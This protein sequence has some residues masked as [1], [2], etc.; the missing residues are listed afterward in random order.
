M[1]KII[2]TF[3]ISFF[4]FANTL[5]AQE[6]KTTFDEKDTFTY[7][8]LDVLDKEEGDLSLTGNTETQH[9]DS[10]TSLA[11]RS[12]SDSGIG[13]TPGRLSV[14]LTGGANYD[15]PIAVPPGINGIV[16]EVSLSYN[17]QSGNGI[18]GFGWNISGVSTISRIPASKF[19]DN[20]ID[21]VDFDS[22][23]RFALDG[24]RLILKSGTYGGNGAQ[25]DTGSIL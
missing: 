16:P 24:E 20:Q 8:R 9:P 12:S 7:E 11:A 13:E 19:H 10:E 18:A 15:I 21:G 25:Y 14:S 23:D 2:H 4:I 5:N 17:S 6:D 1:K 3:L 22:K